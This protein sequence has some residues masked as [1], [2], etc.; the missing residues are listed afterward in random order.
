MLPTNFTQRTAMLASV[1]WN[2][3]FKTLMTRTRR[4]EYV[5]PRHATMHVVRKIR[6]EAIS[7]PR[8]GYF[9]GGYDHTT[10]MHAVARTAELAARDAEFA[11]KLSALHAEAEAIWKNI[12]DE[13][14]RATVNHNATMGPRI[15]T[16]DVC[17]IA[18]YGPKKLH[19]LVQQGKMPAPVDR[20][21]QYLYDRDAVFAALGIETRTLEAAQW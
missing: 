20:G 10:V 9:M 18:G 13:A 5:R 3:D 6:G 14:Y 11:L 8:I 7:F 4:V 12:R 19:R 17:R 1:I 16:T 21:E 2:V 15:T